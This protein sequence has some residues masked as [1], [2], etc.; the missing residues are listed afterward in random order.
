V[1]GGEPVL[2]LPDGRAALAQ[3][4]VGEGRV[5]AFYASDNFSDAVLG[6]TSEVPTPEQLAL[7]RIEYRIFDELLRAEPRRASGTP[8]R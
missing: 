1:R 8:S 5:V 2:L 3:A 4:R 7:Y 6:T